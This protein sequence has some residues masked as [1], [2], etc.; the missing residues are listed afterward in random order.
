MG[1]LVLAA[2]GLGLLGSVRA[3]E[4]IG[5]V[6]NLAEVSGEQIIEGITTGHVIAYGRYIPP[7]YK[8]SL[9]NDTIFINDIQVLPSLSMMKESEIPRIEWTEFG[10]KISEKIRKF[11]K[12]CCD[13]FNEWETKFGKEI[14]IKRLGNFVRTQTT[15]EIKD[16]ELDPTHLVITYYYKWGDLIQNCSEKVKDMNFQFGIIL[17]CEPSI[18]EEERGVQYHQSQQRELQLMV[19]HLQY[20][21]IIY[22][23]YSYFME[24][25]PDFAG[26]LIIDKIREILKQPVSDALKIEL[27]QDALPIPSE[28]LINDIIRE[29][30]SWK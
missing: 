13:N 11:N 1:W 16:F 12:E 3:Q 17:A 27:L 20:G 6:E 14:A 2:A 7:P 8:V 21:G 28:D 30:E 24:S 5:S 10:K 4:E 9:K 26:F 19:G 29:Q 18:S 25:L 23:G 15:L 22:I